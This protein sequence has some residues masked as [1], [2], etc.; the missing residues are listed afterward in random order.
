[1]F[2]QKLVI[3]QL[4]KSVAVM[5][6]EYLSSIHRHWVPYLA[7]WIKPISLRPVALRFILILSH[8][9][10]GL[11]NHLILSGFP[12]TY[13]YVIL[14]L[15]MHGTWIAYFTLFHLITHNIKRRV[16]IMK[17]IMQFYDSHELDK[18]CSIPG[19]GKDGV[20]LLRH[21]VQTGIGAHPASYPMGT[22]GSHPGGKVAGE[23]SWPLTTI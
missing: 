19:R 18:R 11:S 1:V 6:P 23:W 16:Q 5:G 13:L 22:T 17:F 10:L 15:P 2:L 4:V 12:T 8:L 3:A 14:T 21:C 9:C 7:S 20:F